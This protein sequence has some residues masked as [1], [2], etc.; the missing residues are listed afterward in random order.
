M[1]PTKRE[2]FAACAPEEIPNWFKAIE[3]GKPKAPDSYRSLPDDSPHKELLTQ[4]H[5]DPIFDLPEE[6]KWYQEKWEAYWNEKSD[7]EKEN[8]RSRYFQ[9]R[10]YFADQMIE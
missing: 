8:A 3:T 10:W 6:L 9:W 5:G 2:Y 4:W 1:S 7:W